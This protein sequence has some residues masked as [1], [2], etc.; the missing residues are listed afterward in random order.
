MLDSDHSASQD[1]REAEQAGIQS[2]EVGA[3]V[4]GALASLTAVGAAPMLKTLA[5][6]AG[7]PP[8]KAHRYVVSLMRSGLVEREPSTGRYRLGPKARQIGIVALQSMDV[9]RLGIQ[10]LPAIRDQ[11]GHTVVLAIWAYHGPTIILVE[12]VRTSIAVS[13]HVGQIMPLLSSATGRAFG[14]WGPDSQIRPM[15]ADELARGQGLRP[16]SSIKSME[17]AEA[18]FRSIREQGVA[19]VQGDLNPLISALSAPVFDFRGELVAAI[20]TLGPSAV[21]DTAPGGRPSL[22]LRQ[23]AEVLSASLGYR[24]QSSSLTVDAPQTPDA[25][26]SGARRGKH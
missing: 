9:M 8:A 16:A 12:E 5:E 18:L 10:E 22:A 23:A 1:G 26:L 4:L 25:A 3:R 15:L 13:A 14:A 6:H 19:S 7:M 2:V 17:Q 20:S 11:V 24:P 21:F